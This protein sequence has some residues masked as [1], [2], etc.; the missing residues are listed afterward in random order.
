MS[1]Q[2]TRTGECRECLAKH[3]LKAEGYAEELREDA[4]RA[5]EKKQLLKNLMLAE[6]HAAA[7]GD[8]PARVAIREA[9]LAA[10]GGAFDGAVKLYD[11]LFDASCGC[12][13][14]QTEEH[15]EHVEGGE[16]F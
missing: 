1:D 14:K 13:K 4:S 16:A 8:E 5:W 11:R 2:P 3:I 9:R 10:E 7:L 12:R 6:D 15:V